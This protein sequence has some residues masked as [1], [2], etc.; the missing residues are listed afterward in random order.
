M[1]YAGGGVA[2]GSAVMFGDVCR[3][4]GVAIVVDVGVRGVYRTPGG[5]P[6]IGA[7]RISYDC[8]DASYLGGIVI[9]FIHVV[10]VVCYS[11]N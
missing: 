3:V 8:I 7:H 1:V 11:W 10:L 6:G 2:I 9:C 4:A 5:V